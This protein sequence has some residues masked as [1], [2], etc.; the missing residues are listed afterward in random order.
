[1]TT[2]QTELI[3]NTQKA[4]VDA[5]LTISQIYL[6][7]NE[8]LAKLNAAALRDSIIEAASLANMLSDAKAGQD[9]QGIYTSMTNRLLT[10]AMGYMQNVLE[11]AAETQSSVGNIHQVKLD[12]FA[13]ATKLGEMWKES[14]GV[15][16]NGLPQWLTASMPH[17]T[18]KV[19]NGK[20]LP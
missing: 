16:T 19:G 15:V 9:V 12:N 14:L 7:S 17:V 13:G 18:S 2:T 11:I 8:R 20:V 4:G 5:F 10:K 3:T 6:H 1:M